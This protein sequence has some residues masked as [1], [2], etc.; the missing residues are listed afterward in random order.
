MKENGKFW[1]WPL[2]LR[3]FVTL[4]IKASF[5]YLTLFTQIRNFF[6]ASYIWGC[7]VWFQHKGKIFENSPKASNFWQFAPKFE[8]DCF[9]LKIE[10]SAFQTPTVCANWRFLPS[11]G[12]GGEFC[13]FCC[14]GRTGSLHNFEIDNFYPFLRNF[15][16]DD[17][18]TNLK[19]E[20]FLDFPD[21]ST[22]FMPHVKGEF[23]HEK[24]QIKHVLFP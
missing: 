8:K 17:P 3:I 7:F 10:E 15:V 11:F 9:L 19:I 24:F 12:K 14:F 1:I 22:K 20:Y 23:W 6:G 13:I 21:W 5:K 16:K 18:W 4:K 2:N